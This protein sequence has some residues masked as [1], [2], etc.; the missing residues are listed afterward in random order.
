MSQHVDPELFP[1]MADGG[2]LRRV[3]L[4]LAVNAQEAMP[5]GGKLTIT[6]KNV[7]NHVEF[8]FTDTGS[9]KGPRSR[10]SLV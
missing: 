3:F 1:V 5:D 10:V 8:E 2:Q 6:A 9:W 4:N 7:D